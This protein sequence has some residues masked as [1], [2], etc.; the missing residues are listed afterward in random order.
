MS[1]AG[2]PRHPG[3]RALTPPPGHCTGH[4]VGNPADMDDPVVDM[5]VSCRNLSWCVLV[6][7]LSCESPLT[8]AHGSNLVNAA[9]AQGA[10]VVIGFSAQIG[11]WEMDDWADAFLFAACVLAKSLGEAQEHAVEAVKEVHDG[12]P[13]NYDTIVWKGRGGP[14]T[15]I[16][17]ARYGN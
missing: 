12:N 14:D 8:G 2:W 6:V 4:I 5:A 17:P 15:C 13:C 1:R 10:E 16:V 11:R 9:Q 7:F 3:P